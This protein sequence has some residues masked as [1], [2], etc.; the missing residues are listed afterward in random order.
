MRAASEA[1]ENSAEAGVAATPEGDIA[2]PVTVT[3][4][5]PTITT[6]DKQPNGDNGTKGNGTAVATVTVEAT[7][8][9]AATVM[10][11][12][13]VTVA[14]TVTVVETVIT[15]ITRK[16]Y[17]RDAWMADNPEQGLADFDIYWKGLTQADKKK[18]NNLA[19]K[20]LGR[21]TQEQTT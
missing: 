20:A 2:L 7:I 13:A 14:A 5:S 9:A 16:S 19:F 15:K 21:A 3:T 18:F 4:T 6:A 10:M 17:C 8:T 1:G 11:A 12:E